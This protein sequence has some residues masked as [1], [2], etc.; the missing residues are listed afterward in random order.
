MAVRGGKTPGHL[1]AGGRTKG[2][3][4]KETLD[5]LEIWATMD[6]DPARAINVLLPLVSPEKH[7]EVHL[8]LMSYKYPQRKAVEH[9]GPDGAAIDVKSSEVAP[10]VQH[11]VK[12]MTG[13][14]DEGGAK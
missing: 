4:N 13:L 9:S 5:L 11:W 1:K 3:P 8:K 10:I 6:Y 12:M 7:L 14:Q 2:T